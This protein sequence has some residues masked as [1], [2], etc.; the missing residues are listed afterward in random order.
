MIYPCLKLVHRGSLRRDVFDTVVR[1]NRFPSLAGDLAAMIR[2]VRHAVG[3]LNALVARWGV[4][5][6]PRGDQP[7]HRPDRAARARGSG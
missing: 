6:R 1:N 3:M 4:T 5:G 2:G 7:V